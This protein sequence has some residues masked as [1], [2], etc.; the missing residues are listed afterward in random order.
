ME[1]YDWEWLSICNQLIQLEDYTEALL[2]T[3]RGDSFHIEA[4]N[5]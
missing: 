2:N 3:V 1:D 5:E 4:A